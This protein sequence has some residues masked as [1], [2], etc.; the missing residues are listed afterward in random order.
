MEGRSYLRTRCAVDVAKIKLVS[1]VLSLSN[2]L[3]E[4]GGALF[5]E[6]RTPIN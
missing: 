1:A 6:S 2:R 4:L 5:L 3:A